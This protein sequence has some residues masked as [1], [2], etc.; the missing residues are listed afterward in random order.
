MLLFVL[1]ALFVLAF[2][3]HSTQGCGFPPPAP[4]GP[5]CCCG[6]CGGRKKREAVQPHYKGE[7]VPC[8]QV[9][10]K[11]IIEGVQGNFIRKCKE[12]QAIIADDQSATLVAVQSALLRRFP[13]EKFLVTCAK[14]AG[15]QQQQNAVAIKIEAVKQLPHAI[16]FSSAGDG[17]CNVL[18]RGH[19]CQAVALSA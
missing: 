3:L 8:P 10:W 18:T 13:A 1:P 16:H 15:E 5:T 2:M 6:G 19:W 12:F 17:Y 11:Q 14:A 4:A 9:E 7:D